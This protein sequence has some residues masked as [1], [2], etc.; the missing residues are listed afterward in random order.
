[1]QELPKGFPRVKT[2]KICSADKFSRRAVVLLQD[3]ESRLWPVAYHEKSQ[4][5][6]LTSGWEAFVKENRIR[7]GDDCDFEVKDKSEG[8]FKVSVVHK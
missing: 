1:M 7:P 5:K 2:K 4:I 6:A 3:P 8:I